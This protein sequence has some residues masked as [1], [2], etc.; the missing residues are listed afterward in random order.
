MKILG[1]ET[2]CDETGA[3]IV[4]DGKRIVSNVVA[5][6]EE[7]HK[8]YGG[9]IPEVAARQQV[10][11]LI[12]VLHQ[13]KSTD[14]DAIA[15]TVGPGLLGSLLIGVESAK[16]LSLAWEKPLVPVNHLIGHIYANWLVSTPLLPAVVLVVSGGHTDLLLM[17]SHTEMVYLGGTRDDAAGE[18]FDKT[19]RLLGLPY[20][21]GPAI[22]Q[23][24]QKGNPKT[25]PLPRP[26]LHSH[27]YDMSF[28]GLKT[29][30]LHV[31]LHLSEKEKG[32][33]KEDLAASVE[34]AIV[35]ILCTKV[36]QAAEE[37]HPA[38]CILGGGVAANATLKKR[39]MTLPL[40]VFIPP[41]E[42]CTD[43]AAKIATAAY[44]HFNPIPWEDIFV[45]PSL[46]I[47]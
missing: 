12:P 45:S 42:L 3:A 10:Q 7:L 32:N 8:K 27:T 23:L 34:E 39:M 25:F 11:S 35:D 46:S 28:S 20:P 41:P 2:S 16:A 22:A 13:A 4:E 17:K 9:I 38:S 44:Y 5:S 31:A 24:A 21:G 6:S 33:Q 15:V 43:N 26:L 19:A 40:P 47:L 37:F 14:F 36:Q 18:A 1:I 30:V 29:A